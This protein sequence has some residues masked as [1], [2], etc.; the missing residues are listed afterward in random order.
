MVLTSFILNS[1]PYLGTSS[2]ASTEARFYCGLLS[3]KEEA[4]KRALSLMAAV[5]VV[6]ALLHPAAP[7]TFDPSFHLSSPP[8]KKP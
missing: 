2:V 7:Q 5:D 4:P 1:F 3:I 8:H 6:T